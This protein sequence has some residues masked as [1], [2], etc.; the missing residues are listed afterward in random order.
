MQNDA[1]IIT[2]RETSAQLAGEKDI[3]P[4]SKM[5]DVPTTEIN[6]ETGEPVITGSKIGVYNI[7]NL[8]EGNKKIYYMHLAKN[9]PVLAAQLEQ[10]EK[11]VLAEISRRQD[12]AAA[13]VKAN[14]KVVGL[15]NPEKHMAELEAAEK[16]I[17]LTDFTGA[18]ID[19]SNVTDFSQVP[20]DPS[21]LNPISQ[22]EYLQKL[23]D[24]STNDMAFM[25]KHAVDLQEYFKQVRLEGGKI[26]YNL[27]N[28]A[29]NDI[30][31][32]MKES[33]KAGTIRSESALK[34]FAPG[35]RLS[36]DGKRGYK[37]LQDA[38]VLTDD[39]LKI[40]ESKFYKADGTKSRYYTAASSTYQK[41]ENINTP[42][43]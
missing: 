16:A 10:N 25:A 9:D 7:D 2:A 35:T 39:G 1:N 22:E 38:Y 27:F 17:K 18:E 40:S 26:D 32:F 31:N 4:T 12:E 23:R 20:L 33:K 6:P 14:E 36:G 5:I 30:F 34:I 13:H 24:Q 41:S 11:E 28:N 19:L 29:K 42:N 21:K 37:I 3:H 8:T 15:L 43:F